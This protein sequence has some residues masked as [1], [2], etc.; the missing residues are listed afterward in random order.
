M[1]MTIDLIDR[2][3]LLNELNDKFQSI[4]EINSV[5]VNSQQ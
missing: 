4:A 2:L 1:G 5:V 3:S